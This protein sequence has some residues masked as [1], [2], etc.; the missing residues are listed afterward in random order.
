MGVGTYCTTALR[1]LWC[2][3][4]PDF[5]ATGTSTNLI[6]ERSYEKLNLTTHN[7]AGL[8]DE[9]CKAKYTSDLQSRV[10]AEIIGIESSWGLDV[11]VRPE[12]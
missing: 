5:A 7:T 12:L 6:V 8:P 1:S 11:G 2:R 4:I 9:Y 3:L 10:D